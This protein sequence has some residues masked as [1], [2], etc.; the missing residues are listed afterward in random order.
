MLPA[1]ISVAIEKAFEKTLVLSI[2]TAI[3]YKLDCKGNE[4]NAWGLGG[5]F[6]AHS[7]LL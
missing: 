4:T 1:I 5:E 6:K 3:S 7:K 2:V